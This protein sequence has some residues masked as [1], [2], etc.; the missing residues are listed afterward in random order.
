MGFPPEIVRWV[1]GFLKD[2]SV[3]PLIDGSKSPPPI[4]VSIGI[5]QGSPVSPALSVVYTAPT[6]QEF[7]DDPELTNLGIP[8]GIRSYIDDISLLAI[9]D[10]PM[11]NAT[12]LRHLLLQITGKLEEIGMHIDPDKS[13]LIHF[14][15]HHSPPSAPIV[16]ELYGKLLTMNPAL[17]VCWLGIHFDYWL[18]F[19]EHVWIMCCRASATATGLHILANTIQGL[20]QGVLHTLVK[21]CVITTITYALAIWFSHHKKQTTKL[22]HIQCVLNIGMRLVCGAFKSTPV[23][24]LQA[25]SHIP[26][27]TII[28]RKLSESAGQCFLKLP[29]LSQVVQQLLSSWCS[30]AQALNT[31]FWTIPSLP[32]NGA[33]DHMRSPI[34]YLSS[35][36]HPKGEHLSQ[37][38]HS[39]TP[40][41]P[42]IME[43]PRFTVNNYGDIIDNNKHKL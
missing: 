20:H 21:M 11:H 42:W 40:G 14:S 43:H 10:S 35:L 12:V 27:A 28:L 30:S 18:N 13:E 32:H 31:P 34:K 15:W 22:Q 2:R 3:L 6:L 33:T 4:Q 7:A 37:F 1:Q 38:I 16:V 8:V 36:S 41:M 17:T 29:R 39:N 24:A 19:N 23:N 5:P 25:L 26:P 9:S